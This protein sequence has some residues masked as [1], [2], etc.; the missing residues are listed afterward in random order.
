MECC[1]C[2]AEYRRASLSARGTTSVL[3]YAVTNEAEV[4]V[5]GDVP[6]G[7]AATGTPPHSATGTPLVH[8]EVG[9]LYQAYDVNQAAPVG[10]VQPAAP[11]RVSSFLK[12]L[13]KKS[14]ELVCDLFAKQPS[15][16]EHTPLVE[17]RRRQPQAPY[18]NPPLRTLH[19]T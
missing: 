14:V 17:T 7:D 18:P 10:P 6:A 1:S 13:K 12:K 9:Q 11:S 4:Q 3:G 19:H 2:G 15:V 8:T 5:A 16:N